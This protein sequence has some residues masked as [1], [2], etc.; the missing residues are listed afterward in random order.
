MFSASVSQVS[1]RLKG[2]C[3]LPSAL[4]GGEVVP[5]ILPKQRS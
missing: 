3:C 1:F 4:G 2:T 5:L